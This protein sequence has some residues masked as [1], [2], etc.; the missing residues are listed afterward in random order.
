MIHNPIL[1]G[2]NADPCICRTGIVC[3]DCLTRSRT[4]DFDFPDYR[5][6]NWRASNNPAN[7]RIPH[8]REALFFTFP[9]IDKRL[10]RPYNEC[11]GYLFFHLQG[12]TS[13]E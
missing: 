13:Y 9:A 10:R 4:A 1:P 8:N 7:E 6:E 12:D 2:F 11:A 3:T 5:A